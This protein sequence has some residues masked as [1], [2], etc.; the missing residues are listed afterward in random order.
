[1]RPCRSSAPQLAARRTR[2]RQ[3][4]HVPATKDGATASTPTAGVL[5][6]WYRELDGK[7]HRPP[8]AGRTWG[9]TSPA[10]Q[11]H[12]NARGGP[13]SPTR[14]WSRF[15]ASR[16][17]W[18][19]IRYVGRARSG[20][21]SRTCFAPS[22][23]PSTASRSGHPPDVVGPDSRGSA[24][25]RLD[26]AHRSPRHPLRR[27]RVDEDLPLTGGAT[28]FAC[29]RRPRSQGYVLLRRSPRACDRCSNIGRVRLGRHRRGR[30]AAGGPRDRCRWRTG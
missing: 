16:R 17:V 15:P 12:P 23:S 9:A 18:V 30:G 11:R 21:G 29:R 19:N 8:P 7:T 27:R 22:A 10:L 3:R 24:A 1:M 4:R 6:R 20:R 5:K 13:L 14:R 25:P 28:S 2:R 26:G